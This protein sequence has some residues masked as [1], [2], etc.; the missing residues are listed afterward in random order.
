MSHNENGPWVAAY[1]Y[2]HNDLISDLDL[3][4]HYVMI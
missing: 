4:Y 2:A 3:L 1:K